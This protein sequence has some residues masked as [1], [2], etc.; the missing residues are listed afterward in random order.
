MARRVTLDRLWFN[1]EARSLIGPVKGEG[2]V[3]IGGEL[4]PF[5]L[6]AGRYT[7]ETGTRVQLHVDPVGFPLSVEVAGALMLGNSEPRFDGTL[8]MA[9]PVGI[10]LRGSTQVNQ[11]VTQPW[12]VNGKLKASAQSA[13]LEEVEFVYGPEE[14]GLRLTGVA[15]FKFGAKPRFDGL[16]SGRQIDLD[17]TLAPADGSR[18]LP[19]AIV[20]QLVALGGGAFRPTFPIQIGIGIDQVTLGDNTVQNVRGDITSDAGGWNLER[21]E[22]RAPGFTQVRA[23]R[24]CRRRRRRRDFHRSGRNRFHRSEGAGGLARRPHASRRKPICGRSVC[25][26]RSRS[27]AS[28]SPSNGCAP[29]STARRSPGAWSICSP[30]PTGR[31]SSTPNST[32]PNSTSM[33]RS[34]SA[35]RWSP[36]RPRPGR[37]DMTI[38][39]DIGRATVGGFVARN[40]SARLKVDG[41]GLQIDQ[42]SVADLGGAAFSASG[43][44]DTAA[45]SPQGSIRVDLTAPDMRPVMAVLARFAPET[46]QSLE[47][48][49][50][51]MAPAKL[52]ARLTMD[53]A[54]PSAANLGLAKFNIDGGLGKVR[55]ALNGEASVDV[56]DLPRRRRAA[57]RQAGGR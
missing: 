24:P 31:P 46:A 37:S 44:I 29:S 22:F 42:L 5:R 41:D 43:R 6:S 16:V 40:A 19:A 25:A 15:D 27:A 20:R 53:G 2:A 33:P 30:P 28:A 47:A 51:R 49:A 32:R 12:R 11:T 18:A 50:P 7:E 56:G 3:R 57:R 23:Q 1:G 45:P 21:F 8:N 9:R 26:A 36:A 48:A 10:G 38:A 34:L 14:Q 55:V 13:L 35:R 4:Y 52:Q 54:A 39:A 17:R